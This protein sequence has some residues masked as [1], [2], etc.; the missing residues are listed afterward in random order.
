MKTYRAGKAAEQHARLKRIRQ[1][2][3]LYSK[4]VVSAL[5]A[6][7]VSMK[8]NYAK[9]A[10]NAIVSWV[11]SLIP[12]AYLIPGS[13]A[14]MQLA[15]P[16]ISSLTKTSVKKLT[17]QS[18]GMLTSQLVHRPEDCDDQLYFKKYNWA[19]AFLLYLGYPQNDDILYDQWEESRLIL[20]SLYGAP[21]GDNLWNM[22]PTPQLQSKLKAMEEGDDFYDLT[23]LNVTLLWMLWRAYQCWDKKYW[24]LFL[25]LRNKA[26]PGGVE[27]AQAIERLK[28]FQ[29][30]KERF[31]PQ[32][33]HVRRLGVEWLSP[34]IDLF[35]LPENRCT[36]H[37]IVSSSSHA[38]T[39]ETSEVAINGG[40][41]R[42]IT[43]SSKLRFFL[44]EMI[45]RFHKEFEVC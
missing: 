19:R 44:K 8:V 45:T 28:D 13:G 25:E 16:A 35:S 31:H 17:V 26:I 15:A 18:A 41:P 27:K 22:K 37:H 29:L 7:S 36:F 10:T 34:L 3:E 14:V 40:P 1:N 12:I 21:A 43:V 6:M 39:L 5:N 4:D 33:S 24:D 30:L 38:D 2:Q 20:K 9:Q 23:Q 32:N 11:F 42:L